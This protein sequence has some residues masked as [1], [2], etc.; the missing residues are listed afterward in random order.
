[1]SRWNQRGWEQD[2]QVEAREVELYDQ[3]KPRAVKLE[4]VLESKEVDWRNSWNLGAP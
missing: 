4:E 2:E 3:V 1:M